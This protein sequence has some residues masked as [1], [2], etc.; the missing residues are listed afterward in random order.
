ML[1]KKENFQI[2]DTINWF[3]DSY[4]RAVGIKVIFIPIKNNFLSTFY[5]KRYFCEFCKLI[6]NIYRC[7]AGLIEWSAPFWS[8]GT[9]LGNFVSGGVL[10]RE[11]DSSL[12]KDIQKINISFRVR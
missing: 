9:L 4:Y 10:M 5:T 7:Y 8:D 12:L 6:Q 11:P 2:V 3:L 1:Q